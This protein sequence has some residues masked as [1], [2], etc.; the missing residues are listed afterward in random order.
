MNLEIVFKSFSAA[1][2]QMIKSRLETAGFYPFV[3]DE[4]ASMSMEGYSMSTGG[5]R[6]QVPEPESKQA[7]EL[8]ESLLNESPSDADQK[9]SEGE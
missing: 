4:I 5:I 1:E 2:A 8:V 3:T 7:R 6:V 9:D